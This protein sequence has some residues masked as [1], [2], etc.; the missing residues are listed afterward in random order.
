MDSV[1]RGEGE[2]LQRGRHMSQDNATP[3]SRSGTHKLFLYGVKGCLSAPQVPDVIVE[4]GNP[5][6]QPPEPIQLQ[7]ATMCI[8]EGFARCLR[9]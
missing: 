3:A 7:L 1:P 6:I 9:G 2:Q 4:E 8:R 5:Q